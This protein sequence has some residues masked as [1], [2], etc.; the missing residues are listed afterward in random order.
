MTVEDHRSVRDLRAAYG[1]ITA[2]GERL[3]DD[4]LYRPTRCAGWAVVDL[5]VHLLF[6]AQRALVTLASPADR[7][8]D[9]DEVSYWR[10]FVPDGAESAAHTAFTRVV[11]AAYR[12]VDGI[13][14]HWADT[15]G[16]AVRAAAVADPAARLATQGKVLRTA[17]FLDTLTVEAAVHHL[18]LVLDLREDRSESLHGVGPAD[19]ERST[20][21]PPTPGPLRLVRRT[22][23]G[24]LGGPVP[25]DW[26]DASYALKGTGRLPLTAAERTGLGDRADRFPLFG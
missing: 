17:D 22:L 12:G 16:A 5:W 3:R 4:D 13:R 25:V 21:P 14:G 26:D 23:D 24:L 7:A 20:A 9:T 1:G 15:A 19:A 8:P 6:D 2:V 10:A 18:D 11:A